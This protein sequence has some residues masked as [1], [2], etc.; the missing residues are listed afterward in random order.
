[1]L[2]YEGSEMSLIL[3]E[4]EL[5]VVLDWERARASQYRLD[6]NPKNVEVVIPIARSKVGGITLRNLDEAVQISL[7][8]LTFIPGCEPEVIK[9]RIAKAVADQAQQKKDA[10][11]LERK[12]KRDAEVKAGV[13]PNQ[14]KIRTEFDRV[15]DK[16]AAAAQMVAPTGVNHPA[17]IQ[18]NAEDK[19]RFEDLI[20]RGPITYSCNKENRA[21][22]EER[23][24]E[25]LAIQVWARQNDRNGKPVLIYSEMVKLAEERIR[26]FEQED[27]RR[28]MS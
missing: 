21:K 15:G 6:D 19:V 26:R 8:S 11:E 10:D 24:A 22:T 3:T 17:F 7:P 2:G 12:R 18:K 9:Q 14:G 25:L 4:A 27:S 23:R 5:Q 20:S 1:M 28:E 16:A 13:G